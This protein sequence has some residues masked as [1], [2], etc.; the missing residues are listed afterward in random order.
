MFSYI[1]CLLMPSARRQVSSSIRS[2]PKFRGSME[3]KRREGGRGCRCRA[4]EGVGDMCLGLVDRCE[5]TNG[6]PRSL[7]GCLQTQ[8]EYEKQCM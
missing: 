5:C 3:A 7:P 1:F 8:E 6:A 4:T 2:S